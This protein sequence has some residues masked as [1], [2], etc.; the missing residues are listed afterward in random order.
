L[1]PGGRTPLH[2]AAGAG[3]K[4]AFVALVKA[5]GAVR[6]KTNDVRTPLDFA[7]SDVVMRCWREDCAGRGQTLAWAG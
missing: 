3:I 1:G 4:S 5:R 7:E 2:F 6:S